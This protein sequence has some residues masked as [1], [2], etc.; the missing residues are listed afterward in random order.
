MK[1]F[2]NFLLLALFVAGGLALLAEPAAGGEWCIPELI[3][4]KAAGLLFAAP[5]GL[6]LYLRGGI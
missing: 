5:A 2:T 4:L 1:R 3:A 6:A